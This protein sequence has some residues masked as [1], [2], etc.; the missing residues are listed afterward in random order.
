MTK[1]VAKS[2]LTLSAEV[3]RMAS[4]GWGRGQGLLLVVS[5][6][7]RNKKEQVEFFLLHFLKKVSGSGQSLARTQRRKGQIE[8]LTRH[9]LSFGILVALFTHRQ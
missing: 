3:G 1:L 9:R 2:Q 8:H 7:E 4:A 6:I 5:L